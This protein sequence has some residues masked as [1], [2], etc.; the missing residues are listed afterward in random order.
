[1]RYAGFRWPAPSGHTG[2]VKDTGGP[3]GSVSAS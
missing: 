2:W 1:V 3:A